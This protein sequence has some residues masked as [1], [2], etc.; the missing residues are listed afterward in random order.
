MLCLLTLTILFFLA[1]LYDIIQ[2]N[3]SVFAVE[4]SRFWSFKILTASSSATLFVTLLGAMLVRRQFAI[5]LLPHLSYTSAKIFRADLSTMGERCETWRVDLHNTGLGSAI[6]ESVEYIVEQEGAKGG[7][8]S[9]GFEGAVKKLT[10]AGL[11]RESDYWIK[12]LTAGFALSPKDDCF[13]FE[14]KTQYVGKLK[15]IDMVLYF[16]SLTGDKYRSEISLI[17]RL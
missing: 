9:H 5:S 8:R 17:P 1:T 13:L 12:N 16:K 4:V 14:I 15:G 7:S 6:I 2:A 11:A 3:L 10:D